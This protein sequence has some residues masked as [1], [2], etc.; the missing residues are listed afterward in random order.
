MRVSLAIALGLALWSEQTVAL[1]VCTTDSRQE[2]DGSLTLIR[3]A[4]CADFRRVTFSAGGKNPSAPFVVGYEIELMVNEPAGPP[5]AIV[6]LFT[7]GNGNAKIEPGAKKSTV[8]DDASDP[9]DRY[10]SANFL[11]R[12]AQLFAERGYRAV[13]VD[14]PEDK[15]LGTKLYPSTA[16]HDPYR[17]SARATADL[18]AILAAT[19]RY[20][21]DDL[22]VCLVGTSRGAISAAAKAKLGVGISLP[23][24]VSVPGGNPDHVTAADAA[25]VPTP[26]H[27]LVEASEVMPGGCPVALVP[28]SVALFGGLT[29]D[30][31]FGGALNRFDHVS[32]A[33]FNPDVATGGGDACGAQAPH[34]FLGVENAAVAKVTAWMDATCGAAPLV[35]RAPRVKNRL[36]RFDPDP[37]IPI[38]LSALVRVR[39]P[40]E[41]LHF[42]LVDPVSLQ[43]GPLLLE[44]PILTYHTVAAG[45]SDAVAFTVSTDRGWRGAGVLR[46]RIRA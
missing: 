34:G 37:V 9:A 28:S 44:G 35:D 17:R 39:Q 42:D 32:G 33:L 7:G 10:P 40:G 2:L 16:V 31:L 22:P 12:S 11:V 19:R 3:S 5:K 41:I 23:N 30:L 21:G 25:A 14:S 18:I 46:L 1:P 8:L 38:D 24:P 27:V 45:I 26:A 36:L 4:P 13:T 6:L 43:G 20:K 15:A 29:G